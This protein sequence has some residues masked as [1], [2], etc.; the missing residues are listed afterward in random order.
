MTERSWRRRG[1]DLPDPYAAFAHNPDPILFPGEEGRR[2]IHRPSEA[3]GQRPAPRIDYEYNQKTHRSAGREFTNGMPE[4]GGYS[5]RAGDLA[6]DL[7]VEAM[8]AQAKA[9]AARRVALDET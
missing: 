4:P 7:E 2:D 6:R 1:L 3:T 5:W 8:V 9:I